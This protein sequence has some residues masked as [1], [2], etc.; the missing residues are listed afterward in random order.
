MLKKGINYGTIQMF[1][2]LYIVVW[3]ISPFMEI[4]MIYRLLAVAFAG[5][6]AFILILRQKPLLIET[7]TIFAL[8]FL[9]A[10]VGI[11]Y[12]E[13]GKASGII[14][15]ISYF[16]M[17]ICFII[18]QYY[19]KQW[20]ELKMIIPVILV[21]LIIFNFRTY[22]ALLQDPA[23]A[24]QLV[25]NDE[26]MYQYLR[27]GI[28]GY[29]L[30][31]PQVCV[32]P[33]LLQWTISAFKKNKL[34]F[35]LGAV[36]SCS[37][38]LVIFNAGYSIAIFAT[39]IGVFLLFFYRGNSAVKAFLVALII[40]IA[41]M[42]LILYVEEFR[43]WILETFKSNAIHKKIN[44][45]IASA[46]SGDASGSIAARMTRYLAS[47]RRIFIYPVIGALWK[48]GGGGHS[49]VLDTFAKYGLWGGAIYC[50]MIYFVPNSYKRLYRN[51]AIM[52]R[53]CN[54]TLVSIMIVSILDSFT[55]A[56][57]G[58]ILLVLPLYYEAILKWTSD[59]DENTLDSK[60]NT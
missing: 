30:I 6:W 56:F 24:R 7:N 10:V 42:Y 41:I 40:F 18:C 39:A 23:L 50:F 27:Q 35:V 36:C 48:S 16:M 52:T 13:T 20:D 53:V 9:V 12:I 5:L 25:R 57:S 46:E 3:T 11:T 22:S 8:V 55:Y 17:V 49:A 4:D 44:D 58:M 54:A 14:K 19:K 1:S 60:F 28:G 15:Q 45:L 59:D 38:L 33:A 26:N 51:N 21:L 2:V 29:S 47:I 37:F 34:Y 43:N 31:Y 32:F